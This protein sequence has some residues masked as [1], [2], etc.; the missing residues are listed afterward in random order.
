VRVESVSATDTTPDHVRLTPANR[1]PERV[2]GAC[3]SAEL[4]F[5]E[6]GVITELSKLDCSRIA[7]RCRSKRR[8]EPLDR[9]AEQLTLRMRELCVI[10]LELRQP[11]ERRR[12]MT[13]CVR[14]LVQK[15]AER[16][17]HMTE[18]TLLFLLDLILNAGGT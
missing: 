13:G 18:A 1:L 15:L 5:V 17:R 10:P 7:R 8:D 3:V 9:S 2:D 11:F 16:V 12:R 6:A 14:E 4:Q